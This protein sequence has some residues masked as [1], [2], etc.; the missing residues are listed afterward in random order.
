MSKQV[1]SP[2]EE[3]VMKAAFKA[4]ML[5]AADVIDHITEDDVFAA[6]TILFNEGVPVLKLAKVDRAMLASAHLRACALMGSE[7]QATTADV[8][9]LLEATT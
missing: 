4:S 6:Q 5:R 2:T 1:F 7:A 9:K 3:V 8:R